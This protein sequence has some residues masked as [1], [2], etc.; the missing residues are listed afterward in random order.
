MMGK[1]QTAA[2]SA[3]FLSLVACGEQSAIEPPATPPAVEEETAKP[4]N[5][6]GVYEQSSAGV[7]DRT[8]EPRR[9]EGP[10]NIVLII[11]DDLGW[12]YL[13]FLGDEN[14]VTPNMDIIG[15]GGAVF[16]RGHATSNHCRPTLQTLITGLYPHQYEERAESIADQRMSSLPVPEG[17]D[18]EAERGI[19]RQQYRTS[20]IEEF[21]T[22]P[23]LLAEKGYTS[24]QSGKW[25]EQSYEHGGFTHGMTG[26]WNW[27][28]A[29]GLGDQWFFTFMGGQ[30][31]DIGRETM[32]PVTDFIE[33][34]ADQPFF[35]WY[36]PALPHTPL[37]PPE[38]FFKYFRDRTDISESAKLYYANIAWFDWGVGQ[39]YDK[40]QQERLLDNTLIIYVNDNGWEQP[41]DAE[42]SDNRINLANGGPR[43]KTS[44]FETAFRT[45][46]IFY[47]RG[48]VQAIRDVDT[49]AS[50]LDIVPTVLDY[51]GLEIPS[52]L[53]GYS[54]RSAIDGD[55]LDQ[56]RD[57][58]VGKLIRHRAGTDFR[59]APSQVTNDLMGSEI[60]GYYRSDKRWHF[61]WLP[62]SDEMALWDL[63][64]DPGQ[65]TDVAGQFPD[66]VA[67]FKAD[68]QAW[69]AEYM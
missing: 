55:E 2:L 24:H 59:G 57:H 50:A 66:L 36:G 26:S 16:E 28:D 34:Q 3:L 68:I 11:A 13:G 14:V 58:F 41:A 29:A 30:G 45:P 42:Y 69:Q 7:I 39:I 67:S 21:A 1:L 15:R 10:P 6:G 12:P 8:V 31:M 61:V 44:F 65:T 51:A 47:W 64:T 52:D 32:A 43:G 22:L 63:E 18:T 54:L 37:N 56:P 49:L 4:Y 38:E 60:N 27:Q 17:V 40:L 9:A 62:D 46:I 5:F 53:P 35:V 48:K 20:A 25:W 33:E 19:L 23:R